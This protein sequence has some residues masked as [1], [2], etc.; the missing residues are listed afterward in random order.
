MKK[1]GIAVIVVIIALVIIGVL[2]VYNNGKTKM[3]GGDKDG[4]GCLIGA[5]YSWCE[6]KQKCL[7]I[8][9]EACP[10]SFC[11]R[12]NVEKVYKCGEYVRVVSSLLG[13]GSTY[14]EDNMTEIKCPVV[15]P[16][17]ISEQC[18]VIENINCNEI[19]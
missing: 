9:E 8:W 18:R 2:Y 11:E 5:G 14:Y 3:I 13:G 1:T 16:D 12:E 4:G 17:Y 7:R 10:E 19:C 6:S 15:A